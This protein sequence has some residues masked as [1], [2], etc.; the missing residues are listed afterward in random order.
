M[1]PVSSQD[2]RICSTLAEQ[3]CI[4]KH[5]LQQDRLS[6]ITEKCNIPNVYKVYFGH[7]IYGDIG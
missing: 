7:V 3:K 2:Q 6:N 4:L 5:T 1:F